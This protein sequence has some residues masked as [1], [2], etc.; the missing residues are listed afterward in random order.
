MQFRSDNDIRSEAEARLRASTQI[1]ETDVAVKVVAG[2]LTLSGYV[3]GFAEKSRAEALVKSVPGVLAL[4]NDIAIL[5][6]GFQSISDPELARGAV[7]ALRQALPVSWEH[8]KPIVRGGV[9]T[10]E[11]RVAEDRE[12]ERAHNAIRMVHGVTAI[13]NLISVSPVGDQGRPEG[14]VSVRSR[15]GA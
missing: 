15:E 7:V 3:R 4:A 6:S 2:V 8:I 9:V 12:R 5:P 13:V 1:C 14:T 10:L 11:G